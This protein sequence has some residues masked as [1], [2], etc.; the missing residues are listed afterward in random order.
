M[1]WLTIH[2]AN[3]TE[4]YKSGRAATENVFQKQGGSTLYA[5]Q[6]IQ[7]DKPKP[8]TAFTLISIKLNILCHSRL[9]R[10]SR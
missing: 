9:H 1:F 5:K 8:I 2:F 6:G 10:N 4:N 3:I 7:V